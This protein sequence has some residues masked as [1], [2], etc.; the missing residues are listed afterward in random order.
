MKPWFQKKRNFIIL[1]A[2]FGIGLLLFANRYRL[3]PQ[4]AIV[5]EPVSNPAPAD[6]SATA[7]VRAGAIA[8]AT[9]L[10]VNSGFAGKIIEVYVKNGQQV[11]AGSPLFKLE[12][13]APTE[14]ETS[15]KS[16]I[17]KVDSGRLKQLY[18][19]GIISR[20]EW[21]NAT[22]SQS[23]TAKA[24]NGQSA[25]ATGPARIVTATT[26]API[27]GIVTGLTVTAESTVL[28][29]QRLLSLG[30]GNKLEA[31]VSLTQ[32]ELNKVPLGTPAVVE[33]AGQ[34]LPGEVSSI[35]PELREN[36]VVS[37]QAHITFVNAG[38]TAEALQTGTPATVR[39]QTTP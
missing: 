29:D 30:S 22:G 28:A 8:N 10:P 35:L 36:Q 38:M 9:L 2:L 27:A 12:Y 18:E 7:I 16:R 15:E 34:A 26:N 5:P 37:F 21:E 14:T 1:A 13:A 23:S 32:D 20:R 6:K 4:P 25:P 19:Q 17:T 24:A 11:Q 3:Y 39:L 31:V 33:I